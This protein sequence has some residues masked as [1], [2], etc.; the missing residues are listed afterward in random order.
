MSD[1]TPKTQETIAIASAIIMRSFKLTKKLF[2]TLDFAFCFLRGILKLTRK[3]V[4]PMGVA[5]TTVSLQGSLATNG[6]CGPKRL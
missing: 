6:T 2:K 3:L 4:E 1:T 5:P